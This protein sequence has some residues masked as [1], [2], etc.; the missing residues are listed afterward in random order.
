MH[1]PTSFR[2]VTA[3]TRHVDE[4]SPEPLGTDRDSCSGLIVKCHGGGILPKF[5]EAEHVVETRIACLANLDAGG[6]I[7]FDG[8]AK[9]SPELD[10]RAQRQLEPIR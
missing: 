5:M 3:L 4:A 2:M 8:G 7:F 1:T 9:L 10:T 6:G